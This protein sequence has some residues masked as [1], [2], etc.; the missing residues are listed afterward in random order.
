MSAVARTP[1]WAEIGESTSAAGI[2]FLC[3]VYRWFGRWPYRLCVYPVVLCHWLGNRVARRASLQYLQRLQDHAGVLGGPP[4]WRHGLKHFALFADTLLDKLLGLG[5]RYPRERIHLQRELMLEKIAR[6]EGGLILTAHIGCLELCQVLAEEV[7][8]FRITVLVHTA[9]AQ[10]FN[11][12]LQRLD[13]LASVEILQ[14]TDM[15]PATAM[16]LAQRVADG[17]F[18][19]IVGDRV[20]L[21]GGRTVPAPFL[22]HTAQF[23]IGAYVLAAAL[24]CPVYTMAC[25]HEG[26]GYCVRFEHF[27]DRIVLPRGSRDAALAAQ[28]AHFA[29]WLETQVVRAPYDWFNFF[30]FWDQASHDK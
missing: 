18:V 19:A 15:G 17:G 24:A 28:A 7:P 2:L 27:S 14:V 6:G 25:T 26:D 8:G 23:P 3:G 12:L 4:G 30:P 29:R 21:R 10:R 1:H 9:H 13:P 16:Q 11:R 22:G 5:G 20:P